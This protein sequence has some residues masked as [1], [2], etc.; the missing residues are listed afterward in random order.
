MYKASKYCHKLPFEYISQFV[1]SA[2]DWNLIP[3]TDM[4]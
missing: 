4:C 3:S 1:L 2:E